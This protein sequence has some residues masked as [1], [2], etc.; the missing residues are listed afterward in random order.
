MTRPE[1]EA[2]QMPDLP[3][4]TAE[5]PEGP[6]NAERL[7]EALIH[8]LRELDAIRTPEVERAVR[9]VPR[10]VFVPEVPLDQ[11]YAAEQHVVTKQDQDGVSISSVSA[12]RVRAEMGLE[13]LLPTYILSAPDTPPALDGAGSDGDPASNGSSPGSRPWA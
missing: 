11:A 3:E 2:S 7:R 10:H 13:P 1:G 8:E 9:A 4:A 5:A 6:T 12:A